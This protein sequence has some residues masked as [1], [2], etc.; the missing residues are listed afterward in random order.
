MFGDAYRKDMDAV[1]LDKGAKESILRAVLEEKP[2]KR[3]V[4]RTALLAAALCVALG[5]TAL[6]VSPGLREALAEALGSFAPYSREVENLSVVDQ[7]IELKV[8]STLCDGNSA[9]VYLELRDLEGNRLSAL[10]RCDLD[11]IPADWHEEGDALW[12]AVGGGGEL[13][14]YD[15][16]SK[17]ILATADLLGYGL[18]AEKLTLKLYM[19]E[20]QLEGAR[21]DAPA[22]STIRGEWSLTVEAEMVERLSIDMRPSQTVIAGVTARTLHLSVLGATLESDANG[23]PNGLGYPLTVYLSD[24]RSLPPIKD[25]PTT[26]PNSFIHDTVSRWSFPEP[27]EPGEVV[28][29]AIGQWYVPIEDGTAQPGHWLAELP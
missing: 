11:I 17:T 2:G 1:V 3:R 10:T 29:I 27:V 22:S 19:T 21:E 6:A 20:V 8:V 24:G 23:T 13:L 4:A 5:M 14:R 9:K 18:P 7:G 15:P 26:C 16:D 28:A 25:P 12:G